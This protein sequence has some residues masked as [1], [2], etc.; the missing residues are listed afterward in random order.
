MD[1]VCLNYEFRKNSLNKTK[2]NRQIINPMNTLEWVIYA[3]SWCTWTA[4]S[5]VRENKQSVK[6]IYMAVIKTANSTICE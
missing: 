2:A 1:Q 4:N 3:L 6:N 5:T